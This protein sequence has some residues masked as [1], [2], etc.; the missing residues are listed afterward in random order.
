MTG[1]PLTDKSLMLF[2]KYQGY[3]LR[4]VPGRY[5]LW[6]L[7]NLNL[8]DDLKEYIE[9]RR[10]KYEQEVREANKQMRR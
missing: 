9:K 1:Q 8:R 7:V 3:E 5:M 10:E 4:N 2:G 6:I